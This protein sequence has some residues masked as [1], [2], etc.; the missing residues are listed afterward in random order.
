MSFQAYL[1]ALEDKTGQTP[2]QLLVLARERGF[3]PGSGAGEVVAWL[4][5]E[6]G[7]GRGHAMAF[8]HVLKNGTTISDAHVDSTGPHRDASTTLRLDGR[9]QR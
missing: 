3:G 1:D 7:V 8:V 4:K 2:E 5:D 9:A 6:W